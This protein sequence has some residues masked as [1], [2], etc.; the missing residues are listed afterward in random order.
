MTYDNVVNVIVTPGAAPGAPA[1]VRSIPDVYASFVNEVRTVTTPSTPLALGAGVTNAD[2]S[3]TITVSGEV[4][5]GG[6]HQYLVYFTVDPDVYGASA[7]RKALRDN[8]ISVDGRSVPGDGKGCQLAELVS[9]PLFVESEVMLKASSNLHT[10]AW[11]YLVGAIAGREPD[12][13]KAVYDRYQQSLFA[14]AGLDPVPPGSTEG[15]YTS[16]TFVT[17]LH[18]LRTRPYFPK[19]C[20]ALPVMGR[21]GTLAGNQTDSPAAGHVYAKTG[22]GAVLA[23]AGAVLHK[24][25]AG[26]IQLPDQRWVAFAEFMHQPVDSVSQAS[27]FANVV[28]EAMAEVA[29]AAYESF[30]GQ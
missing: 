14:A 23:G 19:F 29:T 7:L 2:G 9:P 10:V 15:R 1:T 12:N 28:Q 8:G 21:D 16:T 17:F 6:T 13:P 27:A 11:P 4:V 25:L 18:H 5:A 22:T 3:R 20:R 30:G 24:A 26:Y